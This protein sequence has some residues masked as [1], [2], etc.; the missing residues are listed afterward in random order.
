MNYFPAPDLL[1]ESKPSTPKKIARKPI[2][3]KTTENALEPQKVA[4]IVPKV[5]ADQKTQ[6]I[7]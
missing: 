7:Y 5:F 4:P 1:P 3:Q 2:V 6:T